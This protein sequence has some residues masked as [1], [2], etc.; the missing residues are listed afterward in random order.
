[1]TASAKPVATAASTA[2]PPARRISR[3]TS[4]AR[5]L[6]LATIACGAVAVLRIEVSGHASG[7]GFRAVSAIALAA[8]AASIVIGASGRVARGGTLVVRFAG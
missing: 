2:L 8:L 4:L 6:L 7:S 5:A 3:P 1:V